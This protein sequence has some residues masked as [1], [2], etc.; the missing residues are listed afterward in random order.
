VGHR[1]AADLAVNDF[2]LHAPPDGAGAPLDI[3]RI[4]LLE[5]LG[6]SALVGALVL[7]LW[8]P[9]RQWQDSLAAQLLQYFWLWMV[10]F[11]VLSNLFHRWP[12]IPHKSKPPWMLRLQEWHL[13]LDTREHLAHHHRPYRVNYCILCGWANPLSNRVPWHR[14]EAALARVGIPTHFD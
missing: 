4:S 13:I 7:W 5:N 3:T 1:S 10:I 8:S 11:A 9:E 6:A 14:L 2:V 12:H